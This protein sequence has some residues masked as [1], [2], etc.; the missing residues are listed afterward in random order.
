MEA[1]DHANEDDP[2]KRLEDRAET[3]TAQSSTELKKNYNPVLSL[4]KLTHWRTAVFFFSLFLCLTIVFA[5]SFIIPC[6]VRPQYLSTWNRTYND[7]ATYDFLA[8]Q[9]SNRDK[10]RDILF[11]VRASEGTQNNTCT[12]EGLPSPCLFMMAVDGT[13]G[14]TLWEHPLKPEFHWAQCGLESE[15]GRNWDCLLSHSD[16]I[17][18]I[19][20]Y[21]GDVRWQQ[22]WPS[23]SVLSVPDLDGDKVHDL[24]LV[25]PGPTQTSLVFLC[26]KSGLQIGSAVVLNSSET[27]A[28][29]LHSTKDGSYYVL[30]QKDTGLYGLALWRIAAQAKVGSKARLKKDEHWESK[31]NATSGLVPVYES[32][33]VRYVQRMENID[34]PSSLLLVTGDEVVMVGDNL[35]ILWR[36]QN[37]TVISKPS[38]GHFNKDNNLDVVLEEDAG[39]STKRE[40]ILDGETGKVLWEV[41]LL[42]TPN[43]PRP[44]TVHT[45]NSFS[46]FMFWGILRRPETNSSLTTD[47][48]SYMLLPLH[49]NV[50]L[51]STSVLDHIITFKATLLERGRHASYILLTGPE[52]NGAEGTVV[53]RKRKVKQD[54]PNSSVRCT[55]TGE[56]KEADNVKEDFNRLRFSEE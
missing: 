7:A 2:L 16:Q 4:S 53:L 12:A 38:F 33:S 13:D 40:I 25:A 48:H 46:V 1:V 10:V 9:D 15:T 8:I 31:A 29:L 17:T 39:N 44:D 14:T 5:F 18:A 41:H 30:L 52:V 34:E 21:T 22:L 37:S 3:G 47:S 43:S 11:I 19:D 24:A 27:G 28:H 23:G 20:K 36:F 35:Q 54:V 49:P 55:D 42:D 56:F 51:E 26:G 6:P 32:D 50:L 45:I